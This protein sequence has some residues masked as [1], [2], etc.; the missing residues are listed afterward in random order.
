MRGVDNSLPVK[1]LDDEAARTTLERGDRV[2]TLQQRRAQ[3]ERHLA[4]DPAQRLERRE[5]VGPDQHH[6]E[7]HELRTERSDA[8][9]GLRTLHAFADDLMPGAG[10]DLPQQGAD[11]QVVADDEDTRQPRLPPCLCRCG[12]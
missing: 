9:Q 2:S 10:E 7:D 8:I 5:R 4:V 3:H 1:R 12:A 11:Q 6:V